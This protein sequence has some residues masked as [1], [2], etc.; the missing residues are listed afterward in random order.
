MYLIN[1][2]KIDLMEIL[3][4]QKSFIP[5]A[6]D[7]SSTRKVIQQYLNKSTFLYKK[8]KIQ[9]GNNFVL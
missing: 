6:I 3:N 4:A 1:C 8:K 2:S 7:F 9:Y 5:R